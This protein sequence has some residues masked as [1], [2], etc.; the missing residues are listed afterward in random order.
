MNMANSGHRNITWHKRDNRWQ[1][2]KSY[3]GK[4]FTKYF[5]N[6][7]DALCFKYIMKLKLKDYSFESYTQKKIKEAKDDRKIKR[8]W[9]KMYPK[10]HLD[11]INRKR[12]ESYYTN[13]EKQKTAVVG[14]WKQAGIRIFDDTFDKW[15]TTTHC[16]SCGCELIKGKG[17]GKNKKHLDHDHFSGYPRNVICHSCNVWRRGYDNRMMK[18]H[19]ELHRKFSSHISFDL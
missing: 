14:G 13:K 15:Y 19:L 4:P 6:K 16:E 11:D 17:K 18:V 8:E 12:N 9:A 2:F 1:Y 7:I 3:K 5:K 10:E